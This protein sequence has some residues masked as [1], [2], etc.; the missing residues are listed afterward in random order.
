MD[1]L[2]LALI[3]VLLGGTS[4][5]AVDRALRRVSRTASTEPRA[6]DP[7]S[8]GG[9]VASEV[10]PL[11]EM[12]VQMQ[13]ELASVKR[14]SE[15]REAALRRGHDESQARLREVEGKVE[16]YRQAERDRL[17]SLLSVGASG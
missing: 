7:A 16:L 1:I 6:G 12:I 17:E 11:R 13:A 3:A 2:I 10:E 9:E 8:R 15:A 4:V 14:A 5:L